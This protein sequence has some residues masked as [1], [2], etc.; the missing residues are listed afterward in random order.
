MKVI[1]NVIPFAL[2]HSGRNRLMKF[3]D[4]MIKSGGW[5]MTIDNCARNFACLSALGFTN[6]TRM[7]NSFTSIMLFLLFTSSVLNLSAQEIGVVRTALGKAD[8]PALGE[9]SGIVASRTYPGKYWVH[10]DSGDTGRIFLI[11]SV[12]KMSC[13]FHLEGI[14]AR[15]VEDIAWVRDNGKSYIL[16]ADIGDN[17]AK[18]EEIKLYYF[19]EPLMK[20][21]A[22]KDTIASKAIRTIVLNYP[23]KARDAEAIFVDPLDQRFYLISKRDFYSTLYSADIFKSKKDRYILRKEM[24]FPFTFV[25]AA[26]ISEHGDAIIVKNLTQVFYWDRK[27]KGS[28]INSLRSPFQKVSYTVEPQGEAIAFDHSPFTF[29]T[30]SERPFGLDAYLY[31]YK[32]TKP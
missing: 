7:R 29:V 2:D 26:D 12:A 15:D 31:Q 20:A 1:S 24:E 4:I 9:I 3:F 8:H 5:S 28:I 19:E 6:F 11:D 30:I 25:T 18:R 10:N 23:D 16:L 21:G 22:T 27:T 17:L 13:E 14:D 32:Y